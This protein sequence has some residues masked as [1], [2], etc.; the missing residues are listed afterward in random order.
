MGYASVDIADLKS[1]RLSLHTVYVL[2]VWF[3]PCI[4]I[5]VLHFKYVSLVKLSTLDGNYT[6]ISGTFI[7]FD[8]GGM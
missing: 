2:T 4:E 6:S 7:S 8:L 5:F 3:V 1:S